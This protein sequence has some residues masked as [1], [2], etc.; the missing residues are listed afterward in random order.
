MTA[1]NTADHWDRD[2]AEAYDRRVRE[3][4]PGYDALHVLSCQ[5]VAEAT[6]GTGRALV[7][8]AG[9]GAECIALAQSCPHLSVVGVDPS[10][11]MLAHAEAK[12]KSHGL[13]ARVRLYPTKVADLP[14]FE[15]FDAATL[16][17]VLHFLSDTLGG[18]KGAK[19][20]LLEEISAHLS[21]G[22]PLVM[23]DLFGSWADP[24]QQQ[25]RSWWRH[26]QLAAGIPEREVEKGFRHIDRDIFPLQEGRLSELLTAAGFGPPAPFFRALCFGGW[27][28]RKL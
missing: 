13:T 16:L 28:A 2:R 27:V 1:K 23:A 12:V 3:A 25:L 18:E 20:T 24:W 7:V 10:A 6:G 17:L 15:A 4:I 14:S 26:L 19:L 21:P 9:T 22:A 8:G 5:I 11:E